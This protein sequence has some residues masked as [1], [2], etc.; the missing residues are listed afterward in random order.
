MGTLRSYQWTETVHEDGTVTKTATCQ[1]Y[2][3]N[4]VT[5]GEPLEI[6]GDPSSAE[7]DDSAFPTG[8][9]NIVDGVIVVTVD[10]VTP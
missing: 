10:E 7:W 5:L 6:D 3:V 1:G 2:A 4:G 8:E 9:C